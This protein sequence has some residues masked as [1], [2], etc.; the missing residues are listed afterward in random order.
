ML[1][2][3]GESCAVSKL[4]DVISWVRDDET[5]VR[6]RRQRT[7][8]LFLLYAALNLLPVASPPPAPGEI[9]GG[10]LDLISQ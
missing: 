1:T 6:P 9:V 4:N 8:L 2:E 7:Y 5:E 3:T 10:D